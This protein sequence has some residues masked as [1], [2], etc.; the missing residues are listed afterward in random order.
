MNLTD[1]T[2]LQK[3]LSKMFEAAELRCLSKKMKNPLSWIIFEYEWTS[4]SKT[5]ILTLLYKALAFK[6]F[7]HRWPTLWRLISLWLSVSAIIW[8]LW[9]R[10][11]VSWSH[12][13]VSE[14]CGHTESD[15]VDHTR[16]G[17]IV[18]QHTETWCGARHWQAPSISNKNNHYME[19]GA[20]SGG[21]RVQAWEHRQGGPTCHDT[22]TRDFRSESRVLIEKLDW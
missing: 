10:G 15:D 8:C 14:D 4:Q 16:H 13:S 12:G 17:A 19:L 22:S 3:K 18:T 7:I 21:E 1:S 20:I 5:W 9:W 6:D 2:N 11:R